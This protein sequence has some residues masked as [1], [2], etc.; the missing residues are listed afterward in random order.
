MRPEVRPPLASARDHVGAGLPGDDPRVGGHEQQVRGHVLGQQLA[1][2]VLVDDLDL[3]RQQADLWP[4]PVHDHNAVLG[5]LRD[6]GD[7]PSWVIY[8]LSRGPIKIWGVETKRDRHG[9]RA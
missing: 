4:V 6:R 3:R 8:L 5:Q 7:H 9:R 2:Q 1:G